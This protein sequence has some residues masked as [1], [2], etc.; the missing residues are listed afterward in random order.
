MPWQLKPQWLLPCYSG[1]PP[2]DVR[3]AHRSRSEKPPARPVSRVNE[4][5][6]VYTITPVITLP[7]HP[8]LAGLVD[9]ARDHL[10]GQQNPG[11]AGNL[12]CAD[13]RGR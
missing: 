5:P 13:L 7:R 1:Q 8:P 6:F 10:A 2:T 4:P 9:S 3:A 12:R 11:P